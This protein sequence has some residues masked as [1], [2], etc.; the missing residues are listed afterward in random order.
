MSISRQLSLRALAAPFLKNL[1]S[2]VGGVHEFVG[3]VH[4]V[5]LVDR[6]LAEQFSQ[7]GNHTR[8]RCGAKG[9][10]PDGDVLNHHPHAADETIQSGRR[11][12]NFRDRLGVGLPFEF[13]A[14]DV[15]TGPDRHPEHQSGREPDP[16]LEPA[17]D[18]SSLS[19]LGA[20]N[21][22]KLRICRQ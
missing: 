5:N 20:C 8:V 21:I 19:D 18:A 7:M 12:A 14:A 15:V 10:L 4:A 16:E 17:R 1:R 22:H 6:S 13:V 3:N 2:A 9:L 11:R